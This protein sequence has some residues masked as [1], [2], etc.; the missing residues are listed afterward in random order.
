MVLAALLP[1]T[2]G[3]WPHADRQ[4]HGESTTW[5]GDIFQRKWGEVGDIE[6][7]VNR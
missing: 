4:L 1:Q 6:T 3:A 2:S 5:A 7:P